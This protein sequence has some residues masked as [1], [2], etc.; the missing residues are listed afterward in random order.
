MIR[1]RHT[2]S[3]DKNKKCFRVLTGKSEE[4]RR[5][6]KDNIRK[7]LIAI[8]WGGVKRIHVAQDRNKF[9]DLMTTVMTLR[10]Q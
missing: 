10:I 7:E 9:R 4:M 6:W 3:V 1:A 2:A 8:R 5:R